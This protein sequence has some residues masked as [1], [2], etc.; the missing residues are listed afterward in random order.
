MIFAQ[1]T[2]VVAVKNKDHQRATQFK[3]D[4]IVQL[5]ELY[6]QCDN[7]HNFSNSGHFSAVCDF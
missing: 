4:N 3:I 6:G 1:L 7:G 5:K 2:L